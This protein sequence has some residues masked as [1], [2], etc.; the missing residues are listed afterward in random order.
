MTDTLDHLVGHPERL[1]GSR[2]CGIAGSGKSP[3][4]GSPNR[5]VFMTNS[6]AQHVRR[7][8]G[9]L[10]EHDA[11]ESWL[12]SHRQRVE[13]KGEQPLHPVLIEFQELIDTDA[14]VRL[15]VHQ[16]ISQVP[17][18]KPY[19]ERPLKTVEQ[20]LRMINEVLTMA[21]EFGENM[22]ATPLT[23]ILDWT[24]GTTAGFAAYRDPRINAIFNKILTSWCRFLDSPESL[25]VLND[26]PTGWK[27]D[28]ARRAIG[29][30]EF[31]HNPDDQHWGFRSWN[32]FFTRRFTDGAR[33]VA[34]PDDD[35]VIVS[36][37]ESTPYRIS[38]DVGR[39]D[40]FWIKSQPYSLQDMLAQD[41]SVD[42]FVGGTVSGL[43]E[44]D[45]L[46]PLAQSG[47]RHHCQGVGSAGHLLLRGRV[48]GQ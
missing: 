39:R 15:Y 25:Y 30:E 8:A 5:V 11:L 16:M 31:D 34:S 4:I 24:I 45:K 14:I 10:P 23:A 3:D 27:C 46:S 1:L 44:P 47:G 41:D 2:A 32:D 48:G 37:C 42:Q 29:I 21:P 36:A 38:M 33:P 13:A 43:F 7:R 18:S 12:G 28:A 20:M 26:S 22:V 35:T 9:W 6:N 19:S 40:R 17:Q